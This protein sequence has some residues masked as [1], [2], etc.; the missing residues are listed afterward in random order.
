MTTLATPVVTLE[1][2][3]PY[4]WIPSLWAWMHEEEDANF[5]DAGRQPWSVFEAMIL[6]RRR[7][8]RT[9]GVRADGAPVGFIGYVPTTPEV[10]WLHGICFTRTACGRGIAAEAFAAVLRE[11]AEAHVEKVCAAVFAD[12]E[13][14]IR[15]L[16]RFGAVDEGYQ[17]AQTRRRGQPVDVRLLAIMIKREELCR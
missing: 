1:H 3:F 2:T 16:R 4:T 14:V 12:N 10:G 11:L 6:E 13:R 8:E 7:T 9:W 5:D 15:F 17:V